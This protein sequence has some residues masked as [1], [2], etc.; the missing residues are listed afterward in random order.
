M[1]I[2]KLLKI[3]KKFIYNESLDLLYEFF[4]LFSEA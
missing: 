2:V 1:K 3:Y 4:H